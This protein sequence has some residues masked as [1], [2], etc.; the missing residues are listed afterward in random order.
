MTPTPS[1]LWC[2]HPHPHTRR[3][4]SLSATRSALLA[5]VCA[6]CLRYVLDMEAGATQL[7]FENGYRDCDEKG[8]LLDSRKVWVD[9]GNHGRKAVGMKLEDFCRHPD[10]KKARLSEAEVAAL[11]LYTTAAFKSINAPL[12]EQGR[13]QP[14][15]LAA[16]VKLIHQAASKLRGAHKNRKSQTLWRGMKQVAVTENFFE[17]GGGTEFAPMSTTSELAVAM[18]YAAAEH[19][20][21]LQIHVESHLTLGANVEFLSA[22]PRENEILYPPLTYLQPID[23][24][25]PS[26]EYMEVDGMQIQVVDVKP[27]IA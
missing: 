1:V 7:A 26:L 12:R 21:L 23:G 3:H 11:R 4:C 2:P 16:T 22:F 17:A 27:I 6:E 14:H 15:P 25:K 5:S 20:V 24:T 8:E 10:A 19:A 18:D 13:T 9:D